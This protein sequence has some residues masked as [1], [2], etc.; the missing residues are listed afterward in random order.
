M[1]RFTSPL[2]GLPRPR[3]SKRT[4]MPARER[5]LT[6]V[7]KLVSIQPSGTK[8]ADDDPRRIETDLPI[9]PLCGERVIDHRARAEGRQ[10]GK[11]PSTIRRFSFP[12]NGCHYC[13]VSKSV[14]GS[15]LRDTQHITLA[16]ERT[17]VMAREKREAEHPGYFIREHVI[18]AGVPV[19]EAAKRLGVG[20]PAL[21]NLLNGNS[22]LSSEMAVRLEKA[23]GANGNE[24]LERQRKFDRRSQL[25]GERE[26]VVRPYVPP[27]LQIRSLHIDE[28]ADPIKA[29]HLL[30]VLLRLLIVSTHDGLSR[31]TFPGHD[32]GQRHGWDGLVEADSVTPWIPKGP[33]CWEFGTSR[34]PQEK[35]NQD[36]RT[37][38]RRPTPFTDRRE[39]TFVFI[40]P[41]KWDDAT[42]WA[43]M[44]QREGHW[45]AVKALDASDLETWLTQSIP[46]QIWLAPQL[47]IDTGG[48]ETLES[49]WDRWS[50]ASSPRL[51]PEVF[52]PSL[53]AY[54][55]KVADWLTS[56]PERPFVISADSKGEAIAFLA[57]VFREFATESTD[58]GVLTR[59]ADLAALFDSPPALRA[60]AASRTRFLPIVRSDECERELAPVHRRMHCVTVR[61][62]NAV[63]S[64]PDI[65]LDLL[66]HEVF[67]QALDSMGIDDRD[68]TRRLAIES[69]RSPTILRRRLSNIDA[70]SRPSWAQENA[71]ARALIPLTLVGAWNGDS[72]ADRRVVGKLAHRSYKAI[73]KDIASILLVDDSPVWAVGQHRGVASK[74]DALFAVSAQVT[75]TDLRCLFTVARYV[76]AETDPALELPEDQRWAAGLYGKVRDHSAALR[77][78]ICETLVI[79]AV[80]GNN[81]FLNRLGL[82][83]EDEVSDLIRKLLTPLTLET[84][85]SQDGDLPRYAE[86]APEVFLRLIEDD[87]RAGS[88]V[89]L[90]L[91]KPTDTGLFSGCP[92]TG[93]L[94]ALES[95]AWKHLARVNMILGRLS[96]TA[97][98]DNW[99]HKPI[100]SLKAIYRSWLPQ[101]AASLED[102]KKGIKSLASRFP[103][104]GWQ[105]CMA[106][107]PDGKSQI[108]HDSHRPRWRSD[109][110]GAG[111]GVTRSE[112]REFT[113]HVLDILHDWPTLD[114]GHVEDLVQ[115]A[116]WIPEGDQARV[117]DR[118]IAWGHARGDDRARSELREKI[119]RWY[120]TRYGQ[121]RD[122]SAT[123]IEG[124][125]RTFESLEPQNL[126]VRH[127]WLFGRRWVEPSSEDVED[128]NSSYSDR[129]EIIREQRSAAITEIWDAHGQEG[130][131]SF[132]SGGAGADIVGTLLARVIPDA[133]RAGFLKRCL[134]VSGELA[135]RVDACLQGFLWALTGDD[136]TPLL[137]AV[138]D[139]GDPTRT[140]RLLQCAPF[141]RV[142]WQL[143]ERAGRKAEDAYWGNVTPQW[144]QHNEL[145]LTELIDRLL[146]AK[147]PRDA[148]WA[149]RRDWSLVETSR[150]RRLLYDVATQ[151]GGP[152]D[153]YR[154]DAFHIQEALTSLN[155]RAG[156]IREDMAALEFMYLDVIDNSEYGLPN[157]EQQI[158]SS[159]ALYFRAL[160]LAFR[161][162]DHGHEPPDWQIDD[163]QRAAAIASKAR[164]LL[165]RVKRLP[166]TDESGKVHLTALLNWIGEL[167]ELCEKHDRAAIGDRAIG[168]LFSRIDP[169]PEEGAWPRVEVCEVLERTAAKDIGV[170]FCIGVHNARG[171]HYR[172][173]DGEPE[174]RLSARFR[175]LAS[176]HAFEYPFVA[177][178]LEE[179][180]S[181]YDREAKWHDTEG[182]VR[183]RLE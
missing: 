6:P 159:P 168:Q 53:L 175:R 51:T 173:E 97:I 82:D 162:H 139:G 183:K 57:C 93:L 65:A 112:R 98:N 33:S 154:L 174:R 119:R 68:T 110:T 26:I 88:P 128:E 91:L 12:R 66:N 116:A 131:I 134:D 74:I 46:A 8:A 177:G 37:A 61:P 47:K 3:Y 170:G 18:P 151:R 4:S 43:A 38:L 13:A 155:E 104:V 120:L 40:T 102:R 150:L 122:L 95:L 182:E 143:V 2:S 27:F 157:L 76:L 36:Y 180:A 152:P 86:A 132:L 23:F 50:A 129:E 106:Q 7:G 166:G 169:I 179:I 49:F 108:G 55:K 135:T 28:W 125:R 178:L 138:I 142:T 92:R 167:R 161:H 39:T 60:L 63:Q 64:D 71:T 21:S 19:K 115:R 5:C 59:S 101:T 121:V 171:V 156:V 127:Q 22:S 10:T 11:P 164:K 87:L 78:G 165:D 83:I 113:R 111:R 137:Q 172:G 70:I 144:A 99:V 136:R 69:G 158:T 133:A 58:H 100:H 9:K 73:E 123:T 29:R 141:R 84:L 103:D 96:R 34:R 94:W 77:S 35:A 41:R 14:Y 130:V 85:L 153:Q 90:G 80:H 126:I 44:K 163:P 32:D 176:E 105:V 75:Q 114:A 24:L 148:F 54:R 20:R 31:V 15:V 181:D 107:L 72:Q 16:R 67:S 147:R 42:D 48:V 62:R 30:P 25:G 149:A 140:V 89:V 117:W 145:E 17:L 124:A 81:L 52:R 45:K 160:A 109:A 1:N 79:L 146:Q 56:E 118:I